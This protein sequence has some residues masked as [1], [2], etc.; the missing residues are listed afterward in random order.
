[1]RPTALR[2]SHLLGQTA[3]YL[4]V[5]EHLLDPLQQLFRFGQLQPERVPTQVA[6]AFDAGHLVHAECR[7]WLA[8]SSGSMTT[9]TLSLMPALAHL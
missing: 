4:L 6:I 9:C 8:S 7:C 1:M 3:A 2:A 5:D